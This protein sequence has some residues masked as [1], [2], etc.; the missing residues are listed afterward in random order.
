MSQTYSPIFLI[1]H[2]SS[3]E[4]YLDNKMYL[5]THLATI[6][7]PLGFSKSRG[8][9]KK[10]L[11]PSPESEQCSDSRDELSPN[12]FAVPGTLEVMFRIP[13]DQL[14]MKIYLSLFVLNT[15]IT[16]MGQYFICSLSLEF[17]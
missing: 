11:S 9:K 7:N 4:K 6:L 13:K 14:I 12:F 1:G 10:R 16:D 3:I 5:K 15:I 2:I 17:H 8:T